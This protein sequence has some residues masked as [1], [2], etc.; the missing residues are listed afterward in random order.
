M[1]QIQIKL[2]LLEMTLVRNKKCIGNHFKKGNVEFY[3]TV[4]LKFAVK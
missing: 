2:F 1:K 4:T 3:F